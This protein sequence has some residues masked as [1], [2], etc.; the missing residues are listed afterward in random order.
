M[1][2]G[3]FTDDLWHRIQAKSDSQ[4]QALWLFYGEELTL[5]QIAQIMNKNISSIKVLLHRSRQNLCKEFSYYMMAYKNDLQ[6]WEEIEK[7]AVYQ[8]PTTFF[9]KEVI[10]RG[11]TLMIAGV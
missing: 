7:S 9:H 4:Y 6:G 11:C 5:K 2:N 1:I 8:R 3:E 10:E